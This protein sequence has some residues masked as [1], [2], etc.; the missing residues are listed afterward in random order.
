MKKVI[1]IGMSAAS[2]SFVVKLR[3]LDKNCEIICFSAE[4][5]YPYNRCFLADFLTQDVSISDILLKPESFFEQ[6]NIDVKLNTLVTKIDSKNK[7]VFVGSDIYH[8]DYLFLGVGTKPYQLEFARQ[9]VNQGLENVF[10][11]HTLEDINCIS[12]YIKTN[13]VK[14]ACVIGGGLNGIEAVSSLRSLH[15]SVSVVEGQ[16][17]ILSG[18]VDEQVAQWIARK[19]RL[20]GVLVLVSRRA[21]NFIKQKCNKKVDYVQLDTGSRIS[22]DMVIIAAGSSVNLDLIH[23][24]EIKTTKGSIVVDQ[25]MKTSVDTVFAGGDVCLVKDM[26]TGQISRSTTWSDAMLQG[27][28]AATNV[29]S[30]IVGAATRAYPGMV[31]LRDSYFFGKDFYACGKTVFQLNE[32]V[33]IVEKIDDENLKKWYLQ[34]GEL[35]GFVLIGDVSGLAGYKRWYATKQK[36]QKSDL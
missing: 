34:D 26:M 19:M 14:I 28:C 29:A 22:T 2:V 32:N 6:N 25:F 7:S 8:Y 17:S 16:K 3:S 15:V 23:E 36:V 1:V 20:S 12:N 33:E 4:K 11:F 18:Q 5:D 27:L 35:K 30:V 31:G 10:N 13:N 24:T 21:S 9:D